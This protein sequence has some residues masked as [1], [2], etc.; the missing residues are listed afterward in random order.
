MFPIVQ[1]IPGIAEHAA[2]VIVDTIRFEHDHC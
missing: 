2:F 1:E